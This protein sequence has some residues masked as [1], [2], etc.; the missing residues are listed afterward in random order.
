MQREWGSKGRS[1]PQSSR[2]KADPGEPH[3][4]NDGWVEGESEVDK[5][6]LSLD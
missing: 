2:S 1:T 4:G 5:E 3:E 6:E